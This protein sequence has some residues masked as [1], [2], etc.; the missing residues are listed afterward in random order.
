MPVERLNISLNRNL[1]MQAI[2]YPKIGQLKD[3]VYEVRRRAKFDGLDNEGNPIYKPAANLPSLS[4]EGTVKLHGTN[5]SVVID[6]DG[7]RYQSR[8]RVISV[9]DDNA[10]FAAFAE[11]IDW[12][13]IFRNLTESSEKLIVYGE[14]C[15]E[16]IQS[17]VAVSELPKRFVVFS[18]LVDDRWADSTE[19]CGAD[20]P[21]NHVEPIFESMLNYIKIDFNQPQL[22]QNTLKELTDKIETECPYAKLHG[23]SGIGEG[24]V[25]KCI[26]AGYEDLMFKVKGDKHSKSRVKTLSEVDLATLTKTNN[27]A[28][29]I[30]TVERMNQGIDYIKEMGLDVTIRSLGPYLKHVVS[31]CIAEESIRIEESGMTKKQLG[32]PLSEIAKNYFM[33]LESEL[34]A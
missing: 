33:Q 15:G 10:G 16:G 27:L 2:K 25:W 6:S 30:M 32:K 14:W 9:G 13:G 11:K 29:Q 26:S 4:F 34:A 24:A 18:I 5:A 1:T 23:V 3:A 31:D 28:S 12:R 8:N 20:Y 22:V 19:I 17:G 7:I 21:N